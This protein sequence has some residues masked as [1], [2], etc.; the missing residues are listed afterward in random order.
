MSWYP[1]LPAP[2]PG[3]L[4]PTVRKEPLWWPQPVWV[5]VLS[6]SI[7]GS[8]MH[9]GMVPFNILHV[10]RQFHAQELPDTPR[11]FS[12]LRF[13]FIEAWKRYFAPAVRRERFIRLL[14]G[15]PHSSC[16]WASHFALWELGRQLFCDIH[17]Q[18]PAKYDLLLSGCVAGFSAGLAAVIAQP[19]DNLRRQFEQASD[20]ALRAKGKSRIRLFIGRC[21]GMDSVCLSRRS[22]RTQTSCGT[23][24]GGIDYRRRR[25]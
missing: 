8:L 2:D 24:G 25:R 19:F 23:S 20:A 12:L 5:Y 16:F 6:G 7:A 4:S 1:A 21:Q 10:V 13:S 18:Y 14:A 9:Y 22:R 11:T 3:P 17:G 15:A